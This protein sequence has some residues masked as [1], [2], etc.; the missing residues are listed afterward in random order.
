MAFGVI[1][2]IGYL[3]LLVA[4]LWWRPGRGPAW[5]IA[6]AAVSLVAIAAQIVVGFAR[7]LQVHIPLGVSIFGV[8]LW[9]AFTLFR[10]ERKRT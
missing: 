9:L 2:W 1:Q 8:N 10:Y 4:I 6:V 7:L 3:A 5:P